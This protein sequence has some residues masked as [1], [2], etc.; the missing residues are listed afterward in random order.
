MLDNSPRIM[1]P[2][3]VSG[4]SP[5]TNLTS[6]AA[7]QPVYVWAVQPVVASRTDETEWRL[8]AIEARV[9]Q[10]ADQ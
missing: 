8:K 10:V 4:R 3:G 1:S 7:R 2:G 5:L 9:I 6:A